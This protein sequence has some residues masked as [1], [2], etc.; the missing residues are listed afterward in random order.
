MTPPC[1]WHAGYLKKSASLYPVYP[2]RDVKGCIIQSFDVICFLCIWFVLLHNQIE[3]RGS[4]SLKLEGCDCDWPFADLEEICPKCF[5][6]ATEQGI[7]PPTL[8]WS[9]IRQLTLGSCCNAKLHEY[10]ALFWKTNHVNKEIACV[11]WCNMFLLRSRFVKLYNQIE[12]RNLME[13]L[14]G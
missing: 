4:S 10:G 1:F 6:S 9:Y 7:Q 5:T 3:I 13:I 12:N 14:F 2:A 11:L 8:Q